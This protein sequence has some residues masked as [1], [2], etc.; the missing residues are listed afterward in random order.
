MR[1]PSSA[2][3]ARV[4]RRRKRRED[5]APHSRHG[6]SGQ[7]RADGQRA[8]PP[9]A[10][11]GP[12]SR[13]RA[14]DAPGSRARPRHLLLPAGGGAQ[15]WRARRRRGGRLPALVR[16]SRAG[17][18]SQGGGEPAGH[19]GRLWH[20]GA[21]ERAAGGAAVRSAALG[22]SVP[23]HLLH[24]R[25]AGARWVRGRGLAPRLAAESRPGHFTGVFPRARRAAEPVGVGAAAAGAAPRAAGPS[26][27]L[28]PLLRALARAGVFGASH[29][30]VR[31]KGRAGDNLFQ[32]F[33]SGDWVSA[34]SERQVV[35]GPGWV[36]LAGQRRSG[37]A[38]S[39]V[40][41]SRRP[42]RRIW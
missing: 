23:R 8:A 40:Q 29:V 32:P 22:A 17:A 27:T 41:V 13:R 1:E 19:G 24:R 2:P 15:R 25:P 30:L 34:G 36:V 4:Q 7:A 38:S 21:G 11:W 42:W 28:E 10:L 18:E 33:R 5:A 31:A 26:L 20:G 3:S 37:C 9:R 39:R 35:K 16:A 6:G 12:E 14:P